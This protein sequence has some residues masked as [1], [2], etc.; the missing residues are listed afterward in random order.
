METLIRLLKASAKM[1][2]SE[3]VEDK[4]IERGLNIL[5]KTQFSTSFYKDLKELI[6]EQKEEEIEK[7]LFN[8]DGIKVEKIGEEKKVPLITQEEIDESILLPNDDSSKRIFERG[9][10]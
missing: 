1:R 9:E 4:D 5:N 10:E 2:L 6:E 8:E 7:G 3:K